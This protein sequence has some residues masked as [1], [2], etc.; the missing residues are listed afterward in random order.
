LKALQNQMGILGWDFLARNDVRFSLEG[1]YK[2]YQNLPTGTIPGVTDY[3]VQTNTGTGYGGREDDFQSFGYFPLK[4]DATG[5]SYGIEFLMQKKFSEIPCYGLMSFTINKTELTAGNRVVYPGQYDQRF[6]F[7][8]SGGYIFNE[9][10]EISTKFRYFTGVPYSPVYRPTQNSVNPG[11]I[12]NLPNEYL[13]A[14]LP[15]GHHLDIRV[16]RYFTLGNK[17][18]IAYLDIQNIYNYKIPVR[19]SYDF[20]NDNIETSNSIGILPSIGIS[21]EF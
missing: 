9:K 5:K 11:N 8:L 12:Q 2:R 6:I 3:I 13:S 18:L 10:W 16:D 19:P 1:Y 17:T 7:N 4:S 15:E 20:W 21:L 14:R